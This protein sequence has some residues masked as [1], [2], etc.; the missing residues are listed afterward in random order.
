MKR[1]ATTINCV[2]FVVWCIYKF[3]KN[4]KFDKINGDRL[5]AIKLVLPIKFAKCISPN[6]S[7]SREKLIKPINY[8]ASHLLLLV[9][10]TII[11][12]NRAKSLKILLKRNGDSV[13]VCRQPNSFG[14]SAKSARKIFILNSRAH[15]LETF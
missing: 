13:I 12:I 2:E 10:G 15:L 3:Q 8:G 7:Q 5:N 11:N 6:K 9:Y 4:T 14:G 1:N